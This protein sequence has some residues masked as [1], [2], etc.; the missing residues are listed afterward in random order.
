MPKMKWG[1]N[2]DP[3]ALDDEEYDP[4]EEGGFEPYEGPI[5]PKNVI[6]KGSIKKLWALESGTGNPMFKA[7]FEAGGNT[8]EKAKYNGLPIWENIVW[9]PQNKWRWQPWLDA[10]GIPN[11]KT[12]QARTI[13]A[14]DDDNVGT[15]VLKV[16]KVQFNKPVPVRVLTGAPDTYKEEKRASIGKW[17]PAKADEPDDDDD[18]SDDVDVP[19]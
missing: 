12:V 5:P 16:G 17:L 11:A 18:D 3:D 6:L 4:D 7:L 8:G 14:E 13:T 9:V 2:F 19:F 15:P 1:D 10:V